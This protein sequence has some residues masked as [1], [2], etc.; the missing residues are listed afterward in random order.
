MAIFR[1]EKI[2]DYTI[3]SNNHLRNKSLSLKSKGL[4]SLI[5]S[6]PENWNY[7]VRGLSAICKEG[8][9]SIS[10]ALRE[11]E[12]TGYLQR[13]KL[14]DERGRITE[15][16]YIIYELPQTRPDAAEPHPTL[17]NTTPPHTGNS[18]TDKCAQSITIDLSITK[19][20]RTD[21]LNI[22]QSIRPAVQAE[23]ETML[24]KEADTMDS[25][26]TKDV[27]IYREIIKENIE[28]DQLSE[29]NS[30]CQEEIKEIVELMLETVCSNR[31]T[32]RIG[33]EDKP[34]SVVKSQMLKLDSTHID[35]VLE[36]LN[37]NNTEIRNIKSYLLT[38][39]YNA[40]M[41]IDSYY[42]SRMNHNN[43]SRKC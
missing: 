28:Y 5:L 8:V 20:S 3:M 10:S 26:D 14:R 35:Y 38:S 1:I 17:P 36:C 34:V 43:K 23:T 32:I 11:L 13:N 41:T 22:H 33:K 30:H 40:P 4:L 6:L 37:K 42:K 19:E 21:E 15:T 39:L 12:D 9:E 7:S 31:K 25:I 18:N 27:A 29:Q 2:K 24:P 16:E